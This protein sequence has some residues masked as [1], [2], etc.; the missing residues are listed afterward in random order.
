MQ[1]YLKRVHGRQGVLW[2]GTATKYNANT[3]ATPPATI[4]NT[5]EIIISVRPAR[6][7]RSPRCRY[8]RT[9]SEVHP[10]GDCVE[11]NSAH[12]DR[13]Y[14]LV[15]P[16]GTIAE[17]FLIWVDLMYIYLGCTFTLSAIF[18][19]GGT[20]AEK[21]FRALDR[22]SAIFPPGGTLAETQRPK[23]ISALSRGRCKKDSL[24]GVLALDRMAAENGPGPVY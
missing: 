3:K 12:S 7:S 6:L 15:P 4:S 19:P 21:W 24:S 22:L 2:P 16:G 10:P 11:L 13:F 20:S 18:P 14:A 8:G 1:L 17:S 23:T 5:A 9:E